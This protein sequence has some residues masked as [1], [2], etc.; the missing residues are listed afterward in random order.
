VAKRSSSIS[1]RVVF[2]KLASAG[3]I[4]NRDFINRLWI[5]EKPRVGMKS[6]LVAKFATLAQVYEYLNPPRGH[7]FTPAQETEP[8]QEQKIEWDVPENEQTP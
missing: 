5:I 2:D 1:K 3:L 8:E 6:E 7:T 4:A